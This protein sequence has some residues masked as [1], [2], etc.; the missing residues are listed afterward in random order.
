[1]K[2]HL[3]ASPTVG[4]LGAGIM[5]CSVALY[6]ARKNINTVLIDAASQPFMGASGW[7]EGKIHLGYLYGADS[8]LNTARK[9]IPGGLNFPVLV[10]DL[11]ARDFDTGMVTGHNDRYLIHKK[12]VVNSDTAFRQAQRVSALTQEHPDADNYFVPLHKIIPRRLT[13]SELG[14]EYNMEEI[15][16]GFEVPERSVSTQRLSRYYLDALASCSQIECVMG[17]RV[18]AA[19]NM[20]EKTHRWYAETVDS[21]GDKESF[22]PFDYIVNALWERRGKIDASLGIPVPATITNRYRVSIFAR[23]IESVDIK[24][25]VIAVGPFGDIK[26]YDGNNLYLSWYDSGL[27]IE[28]HDLSPPVCPIL[29]LDEQTEVAREKLEE[30]GKI[31][32]GV[33]SLFDSF[34]TFQVRGGWV[35]A[36]G[37]GALN[38][39][40]SELHRRDK[41]GAF[42][43]Q[44]YFSVDTGKY[45]MAPFLARQVADA[46]VGE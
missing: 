20:D 1:M 26:N 36:V 27:L 34:E 3:S 29:G 45:S 19:K 25:A 37:Q 35:Y 44:G 32:P 10:K 6:L 16:S 23:T 11:V 38:N 22:G 41:I 7:N 8:S 28:S 17:H 31:I 33:R 9:L 5:G 2:R 43:K 40:K 30:L 18:V 24:S 21:S 12:S 13:A 46:I 42:S 15:V 39:P 14:N 4:I